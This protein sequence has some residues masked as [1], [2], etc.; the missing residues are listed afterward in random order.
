MSAQP[1]VSSP[2]PTLRVPVVDDDVVEDLVRFCNAR[3]ARGARD[4]WIAVADRLV[5]RLWGGDLDAAL[6][7]TAESHVT[8]RALLG[9]PDLR[10][11]RTRLSRCRGLLR[12]R[13]ELPPQVFRG[14]QVA[15]LYALLPLPDATTRRAL[16]EQ[17]LKECWTCAALKEAV[18][19]LLGR[20][21]RPAGLVASRRVIRALTSVDLASIC[22]LP[23]DQANHE[24]M[25]LSAAVDELS[26]RIR[27]V[28]L[29]DGD[30]F[31]Q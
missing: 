11:S 12:L 13:R 27:E 5:E 6:A 15:H 20:E 19:G 28:G 4:A 21:R 31:T 8:W 26:Q 24:L 14:L 1:E 7:P 23:R 17:A 10:L 25:A 3:I 16:A 30:R 29:S 18:A 9:H 22:S 2:V